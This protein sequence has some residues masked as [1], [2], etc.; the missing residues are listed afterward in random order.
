MAAVVVAAS[1]SLPPK[2]PLPK[3]EDVCQQ[4]YQ[5]GSSTLPFGQ[6]GGLDSQPRCDADYT[7]DCSF[8]GKVHDSSFESKL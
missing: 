5:G 1:H 7:R 2:A 6:L 8:G 3:S 4:V